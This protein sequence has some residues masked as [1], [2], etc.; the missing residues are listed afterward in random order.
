MSDFFIALGIGWIAVTLVGHASWLI[1]EKFIRLFTSPKDQAGT[2]VRDRSSIAKSVIQ[3]LHQEGRIDSG[4]VTKVVS[5]IDQSESGIPLNPLDQP[6]LAT[7]SVGR[8]KTA[9]DQDTD[10]VVSS[11]DGFQI[12]DPLKSARTTEGSEPEIIMAR[13]I[14]ESK[15]PTPIE[16]P[17]NPA[18]NIPGSDNQKQERISSLLDPITP[19]SSQT[20]TKEHQQALQVDPASQPS[21]AA[22]TS[23]NAA[24][25]KPNTTISMGEII[26]S[27]LS[28]HNI[29]WGELIAGTLIVVCSI[30]LVI[31]LWG[32]L[33]QT[34]RAI[35]TLI[36]LA[37]VDS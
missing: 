3:G 34:H 11:G 33:V 6:A 19:A 23:S 16:S 25:Q 17:T 31:S 20:N 2:N 13:V 8:N 37:A 7:S 12:D 21:E 1:V 10:A 30:G 35:P 22:N 29:R 15:P 9:A 36:F 28:A 18:A 24:D 4:T 5:A 32:P 14:D 26:Q 27:F